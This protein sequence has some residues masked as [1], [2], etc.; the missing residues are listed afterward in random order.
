MLFLV[1]GLLLLP[2]AELAVM[3]WVG[4]WLGVWE[5]IILLLM[6]SFLGAWIVKRQG[7][8]AWRRIRDE[9]GIGPLPTAA[10]VD[11]ALL[12]TAGVLFLV[13]G[14]LT[15]IAAV[16]LLLPPTRALVRGRVGRRVRVSTSVGGVT[17]GPSPRGGD[18]FDVDSRP[19]PS[20]PEPRVEPPRARRLTR[21]PVAA[22]PSDGP[23]QLRRD[24][25]VD[26]ADEVLRTLESGRARR[27]GRPPARRALSRPWS[28]SGSRRTRIAS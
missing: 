23:Q 22:P 13:P 19:T 2:V 3:I 6:V 27:S 14:F 7:A 28:S 4:Q 20:R 8:G 1:V 12:L 26:P 21:R 15:D 10:I 18:V 24:R 11:G 5:T 25:G 17:P 9:L 16:V